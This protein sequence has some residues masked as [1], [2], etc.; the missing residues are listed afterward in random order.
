MPG[1]RRGAYRA[2]RPLLF[3]IDAER[4]HR[5]TLRA[6]VLSA[7]TP[8]GRLLCRLASGASAP[9]RAPAELLGIRFR[10][11]V[12][13][14]AG[15]DKD[16]VA[17]A[18]W[19]ALGVGFVELGTVTPA[20]QAGNPRPRLARLAR[21]CALVNRMGFNN[22]GAPAVAA[23]LAT[24]RDRLPAGFVVGVNI[25]RGRETP[26]G[27]AVDDYVAAARAVAPVADYLAVNVSSPNTPGLRA[28]QDPARLV[29]LL[30]AVDAVEPRRPIL[31]KLA[32][33]LDRQQLDAALRAV[34]ASPARGVI[35]SNTTTHRAGLRSPA[36]E[37]GGISGQ[38]LLDRMLRAVEHARGLAPSPFVIVASG[39]ITDGSDAAAAR[40]AGADL[41]EL[42]TGLVYAGPSL[43][44]EAIRATA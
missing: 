21:D 7:T 36:P 15:F 11:R 28:L 25:G 31:V 20:P 44:G 30:A 5:L 13:I 17:T 35:L 43:I 6:L 41:V 23:R 14:A 16:G 3:A 27:E 32:P 4:I 37:W 12:G 22:A 29:S 42:W 33:D 39:G 1:W 18:G 34:A 8:P 26:D 19:A 2:A 24:A 9:D 38:P 40:Q 10:N